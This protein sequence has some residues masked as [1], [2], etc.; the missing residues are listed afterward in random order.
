MQYGQQIDTNELNSYKIIPLLTPNSDK[1]NN[2]NYKEDQNYISPQGFKGNN[3][4]LKEIN[5]NKS[6]L[7]NNKIINKNSDE[8]N[9]NTLKFDKND[10]Q[11][12]SQKFEFN[13]YLPQKD[14]SFN[15][16]NKFGEQSFFK[17]NNL[18]LAKNPSNNSSI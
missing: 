4:N 17:V 2:K 10:T 12:F 15:P 1:I 6:S 9:F 16:L 14:F 5:K 8:I 18:N 11:N 3:I 13:D 7:Y